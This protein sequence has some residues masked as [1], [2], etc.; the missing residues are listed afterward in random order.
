MFP[1]FKRTLGEADR[2]V[3]WPNITRE[4]ANKINVYNWM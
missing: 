3:K 1:S 4:V 2:A